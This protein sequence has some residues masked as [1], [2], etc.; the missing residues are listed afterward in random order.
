MPVTLTM[1]DSE[2]KFL[3][4]A[5]T[6]FSNQSRDFAATNCGDAPALA[7]HFHVCSD[8]A[9]RIRDRIFTGSESEVV[10]CQFPNGKRCQPGACQFPGGVRCPTVSVDSEGRTAQKLVAK[11]KV[12]RKCGVT[13]RAKHRQCVVGNPH[14]MEHDFGRD[15]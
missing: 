11:L 6:F 4:E 14:D 12:C 1:D 5:L 15:G 8:R 2:A 10:A 3:R 7:K 13:K 9:L